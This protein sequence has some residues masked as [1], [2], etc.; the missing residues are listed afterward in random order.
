MCIYICDYYRFN[1]ISTYASGTEWYIENRTCMWRTGTEWYMQ[2]R[3]YMSRTGTEWYIENRTC[4]WRT[5][6]EWYI[7]VLHYFVDDIKWLKWYLYVNSIDVLLLTEWKYT[8]KIGAIYFRF[9]KKKT[10]NCYSPF[11]LR[12]EISCLSITHKWYLSIKSYLLNTVIYEM[13]LLQCL[14]YHITSTIGII[15]SINQSMLFPIKTIS[16]NYEHCTE[17]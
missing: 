15:F 5:G 1:V 11:R 8:R 9:T 12:Y 3:T 10:S 4:M 17:W 16:Q 13:I 6:T 7:K 2:N 14:I